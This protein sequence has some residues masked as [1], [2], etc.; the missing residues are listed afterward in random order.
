[1]SGL[2]TSWCAA[3]GV[4][5]AVAATSVVSSAPTASSSRLHAP[6][7]SCKQVQASQVAGWIDQAGPLI[8]H[9]WTVG[10]CRDLLLI[11]DRESTGNP[12]AV[13]NWDSNAKRG[14]PTGGLMQTRDD[15]FEAHAPAGCHGRM[16]DPPCNIAAGYR[17]AIGRYGSL[18]NVPGVRN[19]RAG[20]PYVGY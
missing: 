18:A 3:I 12:R 11:I 10:E 5:L 9:R 16:L 7:G 4:A 15:T 2:P 19:V 17:Y 1:M 13:N 6:V 20:L 14:H 8:R